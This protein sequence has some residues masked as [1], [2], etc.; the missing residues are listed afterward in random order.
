MKA[1][2]II[3]RG[4]TKIVLTP[5]NGFEEH[6]IEKAYNKAGDYEFETDVSCGYAYQ[7]YKDH[8]IEYIRLDTLLYT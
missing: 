6:V 5:E 1:K 8:K 7:E 3:E 2:V 4:K